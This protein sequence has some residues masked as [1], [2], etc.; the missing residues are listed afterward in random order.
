MLTTPMIAISIHI[1]R[2]ASGNS[3]YATRKMPYPPIFSSSAARIM[4]IGVGASTCASGSQVCSGNAGTLIRNAS[5]ASR[6]NVR[7]T[8]ADNP[9]ATIAFCTSGRASSTRSNVPP[10]IPATPCTPRL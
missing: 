2:A 5:I 3:G 4:L 8:V 9:A 7:P 6:K 1:A 10:S